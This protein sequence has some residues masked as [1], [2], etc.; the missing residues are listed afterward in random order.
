MSVNIKNTLSS[1]IPYPLFNNQWVLRLEKNI[2][3]TGF[4]SLEFMVKDVSLPNSFPSFATE[5]LPNGN[6]YYTKIEYDK[7]WSFTLNES[8]DIKAFAFFKDWIDSFYDPQNHQFNLRDGAYTRNFSLTMYR[9][10]PISA[11]DIE[12]IKRNRTLNS[13]VNLG[14]SVLNSGLA[15]L[16]GIANQILAK[17]VTSSGAGN[18]LVH[19][20]V[21]ASTG[22]IESVLSSGISYGFSLLEQ[23]ENFHTEDIAMRYNLNNTILKSIDKLSLEYGD[24]EPIQWK[25]TLAS[26]IIKVE[27]ADDISEEGE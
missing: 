27:T 19:R 3:E 1:N 5:E 6:Q 16:E 4:P 23:E 17:G 2:G 25:I 10:A 18:S 8:V 9:S 14:D 22:T 21:G 15:R 13:L 26:D 11:G 12:G 20:F 24:G 7:E